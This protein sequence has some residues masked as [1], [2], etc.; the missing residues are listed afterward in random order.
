MRAQALTVGRALL[1]LICATAMVGATGFMV[2]PAKVSGRVVDIHGRPI[3]DA[4]VTLVAAAGSDASTHS[5]SDGTFALAGGYRIEGYVVEISAPGFLTARRQA[6]GVAVLRRAPIVQGRI[7]DET[8]AAVAGAWVAASGGQTVSDSDGFFWLTGL[9]PGVTDVTVFA[10]DHD[11][12]QHQVNLGPDHIEQLAPVTPRQ[13]GE[14]DLATDPG[15]V[16]PTLDGVPIPSCP[17]TPCAVAVAVGDH[18]VAVDSPLYVPW[19]QPFSLVRDQQVALTI[20]LQRKTGV[21]SV[22]VPALNG[23]ELWIDGS[24]VSPT[25]WSG[26]LPTGHYSIVFRSADSWP[27]FGSA[28]VQWQ[29]RTDVQV[30][31]ALVVPGDQGAFLSGLSGYLGALGGQYGVWL[32]DLGSGRQTGYHAS[33]SMEA[34]SVIKLP[35]ALY[36]LDQAAQGKLKLTD[37]VQLEDADFMGG[38]G[39]LYYNNAPGDSFSYQD[40]LDLLIQQSDN[41]AWQALDRVLGADKVDAYAA[42]VGAPDCQQLSDNCTAGEAGEMLARLASGTVL[43]APGR[44]LLLGLL[45]NTAFNDRINFYLGGTAVAHKVGMDGGVMNDS[46]I[47]YASRP[48]VISMFTDTDNPDQGVQAIRDVSR[49]AAKY[50]SR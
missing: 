30:A 12:W 10:A 38:T 24:P 28:D 43:D 23:G 9:R 18:E 11:P 15:G 20:K 39:S 27:W 35:L 37:T 22:S 34:A 26:E 25:G 29:Q 21:L 33:D 8:G 40:L 17:A 5:A 44:Q 1:G 6:S 48:F 45:E 3:P 19:S 14:L 4:R 36:L 46:G 7:L 47:V 42:S 16:A 32:E 41:T 31:P 49:A 13:F 2:T 50:Y